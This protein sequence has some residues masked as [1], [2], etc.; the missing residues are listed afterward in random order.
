MSKNIITLSQSQVAKIQ[1]I[2]G[3]EY[4]IRDSYG[5]CGA[6]CIS[7]GIRSTDGARYILKRPLKDTDGTSLQMPLKN[8]KLDLKLLSLMGEIIIL[9]DTLAIRWG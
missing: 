3:S 2:L 4:V 7:I 1:D 5:V 6:H 8:L 9:P